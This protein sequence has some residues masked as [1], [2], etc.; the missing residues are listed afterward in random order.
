MVAGPIIS[1]ALHATVGYYYMNL[2]FGKVFLNPGLF[3]KKSNIHRS[4]RFC[5]STRTFALAFETQNLSSQC[6]F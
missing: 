1:G 5:P 2:V 4:Y 3:N 6:T